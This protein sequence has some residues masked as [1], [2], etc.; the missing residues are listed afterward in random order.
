MRNAAATAVVILLGLSALA[1]TA[2]LA[3]FS[4]PAAPATI[5]PATLFS[6]QCGTCHAV[7]ADAGPRQGPNL[8]GVF[9]RQAG[10]LVG[11]NYSPGFAASGIVWDETTLDAYL[12]NP[13]ALIAKSVMAY[14][15]ANSGTRQTIIGWLKEQR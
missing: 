14:R 6:R 12:T 4:P 3:Q 9:G 13:Q 7:A 8:R 10:S 2:A 11:F 1:S 15:Q 5:D